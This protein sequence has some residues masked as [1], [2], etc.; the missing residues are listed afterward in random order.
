MRKGLLV[1]VLVA[2][3]VMFSVPAFAQSGNTIVDIAVGDGRFDTLVAAVS[4]AGLVD[5][6]A[7]PGPFTVFAPTDNAFAALGD[8]TINSLLADPSGAL[9]QILL[10]HVVAGEV[11]ASAVV[12]S[13]SAR[14]VQGASVKIEVIDGGVV[15]DRSVNVIITDIRA[16]N[17]IIHVIDAV[18]LPPA[19][20]AR[21]ASLIQITNSTAVQAGSLGGDT[22]AVLAQ[23]QTF[24]VTSSANGALRLRDIPGWVK[25]ADTVTV[26]LNFGQR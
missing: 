16:S 25:T 17:G 22:N 26:P 23:G 3:L 20:I 8:D 12:A 1:A 10:Y 11:P 5:T 2:V 9:T 24:F 18:L 6:L 7:G 15:L 4:A 14:T 19:S 21:E 13:Q